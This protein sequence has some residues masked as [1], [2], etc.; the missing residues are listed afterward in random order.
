[1]SELF[2][3]IRNVENVV[4]CMY[5]K[6][7]KM[8]IEKILRMYELLIRQGV[9]LTVL[10][11]AARIAYDAQPLY[12]G[13]LWPLISHRLRH[14]HSSMK[15]GKSYYRFLKFYLPGFREC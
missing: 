11:V 14:H 10:K 13:T 3:R 6:T 5:T 12:L 1:M 15:H 2:E 8:A 4:A 7:D 9:G